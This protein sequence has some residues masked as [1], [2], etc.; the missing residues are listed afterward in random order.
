MENLPVQVDVATYGGLLLT[1]PLLVGAVK[2]MW[3]TWAEGK[4]ALMTLVFTFA[5]GISSKV[6]VAQAFS[7]VNWVV[8][9]VMLLLVAAGAMVVRDKVKAALKEGT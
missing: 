1:V 7:N 2:K 5:I 3:K 9:P 4:S 8:H 6:F